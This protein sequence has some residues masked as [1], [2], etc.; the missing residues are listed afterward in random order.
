MKTGQRAAA[1]KK[2]S[3]TGKSSARSRGSRSSS[4]DKGALTSAE[5][6]DMKLSITA[7]IIDAVEFARKS[8][9]PEASALLADVY[10]EANK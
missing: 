8:A 4:L 10:R 7:E 3:T 5:V 1:P 9:Y 6:E 2:S